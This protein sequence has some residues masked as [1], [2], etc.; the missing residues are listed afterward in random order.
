MSANSVHAVG[1]SR[2]IHALA[3]AAVA[4]LS[5]VGIAAVSGGWP[6]ALSQKNS[7]SIE[8]PAGDSNAASCPVCGTIE[9]IR[10]VEVYDGLGAVA[11]TTPAGESGPRHVYRVTVHMDDGS[12]RTVSQSA[13]P[14]LA[15]GDKVRLVQGAVRAAKL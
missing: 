13:P 12:F 4:V 14:A 15:I 5:L 9:S 1:G 7:S 11:G 2:R 3:A 10:A 6:R 8:A